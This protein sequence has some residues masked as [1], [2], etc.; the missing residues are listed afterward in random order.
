MLWAKHERNWGGLRVLM[1][2]GSRGWCGLICR[3]G[4]GT[5]PTV[6]VL[7]PRSHPRSRLSRPTRVTFTE[8]IEALIDLIAEQLPTATE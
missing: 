2:M 7:P 5:G 8:Q 3:R 6:A 1:A 4:I